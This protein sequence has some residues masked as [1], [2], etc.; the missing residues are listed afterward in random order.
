VTSSITSDCNLPVWQAQVLK[1]K[2]Q[3]MSKD[4]DE[5][6]ALISAELKSGHSPFVANPI[7]NPLVIEIEGISLALYIRKITSAYFKTRPDVTRIQL[8]DSSAIR[9]LE[10]QKIKVLTL[11]YCPE[12][13]SVVL[14]PPKSIRSRFNKR[15]NVSLYSRMSFQRIAGASNSS[16]HYRLSNG[17]TITGLPLKCLKQVLRD[18]ARTVDGAHRTL[19][20]FKEDGDKSQALNELSESESLSRILQQNPSFSFADAVDALI[21]N[22][23]TR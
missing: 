14:W 19:K 17:D 6:V 8:H 13:N 4:T 18:L 15:K 12:T 5:I 23:K 22:R 7:E 10:D 2:I 1:L 20:L 16:N 21:S 9:A 11:G 3:P